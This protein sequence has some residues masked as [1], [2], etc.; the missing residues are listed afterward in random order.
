MG[1]SQVGLTLQ[2]ERT[3]RLQFRAK[4]DTARNLECY[5]VHGASPF[6]NEGFGLNQLLSSTWQQDFY[7]FQ[8]KAADLNGE[9]GFGVGDKIGDIWLDGMVL[10]DVTP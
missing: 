6:Q 8:S 9:L 7:T 4:S 10:Q 1:L 2:P 5:I 3:Y